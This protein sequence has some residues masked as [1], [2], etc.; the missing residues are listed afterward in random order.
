MIVTLYCYENCA[1]IYMP[2]ALIDIFHLFL[3]NPVLYKGVM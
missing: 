2:V 1:I 3:E